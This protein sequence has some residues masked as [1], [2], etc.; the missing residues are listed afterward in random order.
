M[1]SSS[2][3]SLGAVCDRALAEHSMA[4][5]APSRLLGE[6]PETWLERC[7]APYRFLPLHC[8][9]AIQRRG[10]VPGAG[11]NAA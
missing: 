2:S 11:Q 5:F 8:Q 3:L 6:D 4:E 10:P 1:K 9:V 7:D